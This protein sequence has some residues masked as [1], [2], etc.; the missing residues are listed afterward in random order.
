VRHTA[1]LLLAAALAAGGCASGEAQGRTDSVGQEATRAP[2]A[3]PS[4]RKAKP[5]AATT[6]PPKRVA[7]TTPPV[8]RPVARRTTQTP[9]PA[10]PPATT[11]AQRTDPRFDTCKEAEAHGYGPYRAGVDPEYGWYQD[12]DSDGIVCER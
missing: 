2:S 1:A 5:V 4:A 7:A 12:R 11:R 8:R 6:A 10:P 9:R 3:T